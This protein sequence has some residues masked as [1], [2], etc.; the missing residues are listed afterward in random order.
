MPCPKF[1][2]CHDILVQLFHVLPLPFWIE[3][4]VQMEVNEIPKYKI[5]IPSYGNNIVSLCKNTQ[6]IPNLG[7]H[8]NY[9]KLS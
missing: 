8:C 3:F 7:A 1:F 5:K 9:Y 4:L 6:L 2:I